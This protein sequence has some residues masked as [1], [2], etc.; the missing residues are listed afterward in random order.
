MAIK[1]GSFRR[2]ATIA[3]ALSALL[4]A[5]CATSIPPVEVTRFH[6]NGVARQGSIVVVPADPAAAAASLEFRTVANAVAASLTRTGFTVRDAGPSDYEAVVAIDRQTFEPG[7]RRS[8]VNVGVGGSTGSYGSGVGLGIG[9]DLS[10]RPKPIVATRMRVQLRRAGAQ[11]AFWEGRAEM[12]AKSTAPAAQPG[13][14]AGQLA[15]ALFR[16]YP[17][18]S[19][20]TITVR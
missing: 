13:I 9:I 12:A 7:E 1:S 6:E 20:E 8:P 11:T 5:G 17:G 16:D 2:T 4:L 14:A 18:Q 3:A 15:D 19:G 10:G